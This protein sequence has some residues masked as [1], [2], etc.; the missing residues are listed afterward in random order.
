MIRARL[1]PI[2]ASSSPLLPTPARLAILAAFLGALALPFPGAAQT[3]AAL[4]EIFARWDG[5]AS[6]GCAVGVEQPGV[7]TL[8]AAYGMANLEFDIPNSP[9][10][11]FE[12]GSVSKQF[13]AAAVALLILDGRLGYEDDI[14]LYLPEMPDY[15]PTLEIRHL[16]NHTSGLRDWG[17]VAAISGWGRGDRTYTHAHVLDIA[18]RQSALNYLPGEAYSYTNTGYNL[19]VM[20]VERITGESFADFSRTHIFE[21]LGMLDTQWRDDYRRIVPGRATAYSPAGEGSYRINQP[22]ENVHGNGGLLTTVADLLRWNAALASGDFGGEGFTELMHRQ[23]VLNDGEVITYASG[24]QVTRFR[25]VPVVNHTGATAGYRAY[26]GRYPERGLSVTVLCNTADANP[27]GLGGQVSALFLG[28]AVAAMSEGGGGAPTTEPSPWTPTVAEL[29]SIAGIYHSYD[30]ETTLEVTVE[31][32]TLTVRRR[33]DT[34]MPFRPTER[35]TFAGPLGMLRIHRNTQGIVIEIGISQA[36]VH[37][38]R[39]QRVEGY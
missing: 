16:L 13:T 20:I 37:D 10:T 15:G 38:L 34:T 28:D 24:L 31:E 32:G 2:S 11:I 25:G 30:A 29:Q 27:G 23:G 8:E 6:P 21:P 5:L 12:A 1:A 35:D 26:L 19:L 17:A 39:F 22:I 36:R 33:P 9:G 14:R 3:P 7:P 18:A 4:D